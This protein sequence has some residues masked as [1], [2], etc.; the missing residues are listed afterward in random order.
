MKGGAAA[1]AAATASPPD[2]RAFAGGQCTVTGVVFENLSGTG[3]RQSSDPGIANVLVS[4]GH[5]VARTDRDGRYALPMEDDAIVF[6]IKPTGYAVPI[7]RG[8]MLP[9]FYYIHRPH[10]TPPQ[11]GT[12]E[13]GI[14]PTGPLPASVDFALT[15]IDEPDRFDVIMF[16]DTHADSAAAIDY[17][18][19]DVVNTLIGTTAAFG[20]TLGDLMSDDLSRY[21]RYNRVIG[22]VGV[23]WYNISGNHDLNFE[24]SGREYSRETFKRIFGPDY[25]AFEYGGALFLMLD[26]VDYL[27]KGKYQGRFGERQLAFVSRLLAHTPADR[28][29]IAAMHIPLRT[30]LDP[31][32]ATVNTSDA[33]ELLGILGERPCISFSGHTHTNEHHY[34]GGRHGSTGG[35]SHHHH[36]MTA[37]SGSW[38]SGPYDH[39]GV[40][41]ADSP[42]GNPNGFYILSI[43]GNRCTTRFR[44]AKEPENRQMR[45]VLDST[46]HDNPTATDDGCMSPLFGSPIAQDRGGTT[47]VIVNVFDGGP[48]TTVEYRIGDFGPVK[49]NRETRPDPFI[50]EVF[51]RNHA[52]KKPWAE[53]APCS[54]I[55]TAP[56]PAGLDAGI[57]CIMVRVIDEYGRELHD[58]LC[59]EVTGKKATHAMIRG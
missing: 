38:W 34:I 5:D 57:H 29:V 30:Y 21:D 33:L 22:R 52:T 18:R 23:P 36:V 32:D 51:A 25:Y 48:R 27:G 16:A 42:D 49:M 53:V 37:L 9:R 54:H 6:V 46:A 59:L 35:L 43:D 4:N 10:G 7:D 28:L 3:R 20:L 24:A 11:L 45:I 13:R 58:R 8:T 15:K 19:T 2:A 55:C 17:I 40:A 12:R 14:E 39:R 47:N 56:L 41:M 31:N 1:I 26:N 44:P 50:Q